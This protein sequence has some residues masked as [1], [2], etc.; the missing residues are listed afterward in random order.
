VAPLGAVSAT[1]VE[2]YPAEIPPETVS[3]QDQRAVSVPVMDSSSII[4]NDA[5]DSEEEDDYDE[6][7]RG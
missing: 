1:A 4:R 2:A 6:Y 3:E 5:A 7:G